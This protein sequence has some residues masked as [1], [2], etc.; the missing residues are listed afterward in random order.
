MGA[1]PRVC[2][3]A[4]VL[5][6]VTS[7]AVSSALPGCGFPDFRVVDGMNAGAGSGGASGTGGTG[8]GGM[9]DAAGADDEGGS[10]GTSGAGGG[11][12]GA[13]NEF[14]PVE[15]CTVA[16]ASPWT[17]PVAYWGTMSGEEPPDCPEGYENPT[18]L[19]FGLKAPDG[20]CTC[21]CAVQGQI[22]E[23]DPVLHIYGDLNCDTDCATSS[24]QACTAVP[25]KCDGSQGSV[26]AAVPTLSGGTCVATVPE[27]PEPTW[28]SDARLCRLSEATKCEAAGEVCA[29]TPAFPYTT[30][31]C[32]MRTIPQAQAL[33]MCPDEYP[34][35]LDP[36]YSD[37]LD[38]RACSDCKCSALSGG[39]CSGTLWLSSNADSCNTEFPYKLGSGCTTFN[40][41]GRIAH[42]SAKYT[43]SP[44]K[45]SVTTAS[46]P[47]GKATESGQITLVCCQ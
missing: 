1:A 15:D 16:A 40:L 30:G 8:A 11:A 47:T 37:V 43:L 13:G 34:N 39:E 45:C 22:C 6:L 18:D 23:E 29:P 19:H 20:A 10:G 33:P 5:A 7:V 42:I 41:G 12:A 9:V 14:C 3:R 4:V 26:D 25:P 31:L 17:G 32:V 2:V 21:S 28:Q 24:R 36:M 46:H 44:G 35:Q 38:D 27:P